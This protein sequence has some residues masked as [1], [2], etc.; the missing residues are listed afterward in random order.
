VAKQTEKAAIAA[1][2]TAAK[3]SKIVF[4]DSD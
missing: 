4:D 3:S 2:L 1:A